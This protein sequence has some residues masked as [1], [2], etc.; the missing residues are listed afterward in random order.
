MEG[1]SHHRS[2]GFRNTSRADRNR[3]LEIKDS[4]DL[5]EHS[6]VSIILQKGNAGGEYGLLETGR[7]GW[8]GQGAT[9]NLISM[10]PSLNC[11]L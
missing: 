1:L 10:C 8:R 6:K 3:Q 2:R 4:G 7:K 5:S 11:H 9:I